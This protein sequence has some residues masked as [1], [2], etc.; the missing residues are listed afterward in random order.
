MRSVRGTSGVKRKS[1]VC[2]SRH[3]GTANTERHPTFVGQDQTVAGYSENPS[4]QAIREWRCEHPPGR[5]AVAQASY[6]PL[7][8]SYGT[9]LLL[10]PRSE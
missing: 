3:A 7:S 10:A 9:L 4:K 1:Q 6:R 8:V 5:L 2:D